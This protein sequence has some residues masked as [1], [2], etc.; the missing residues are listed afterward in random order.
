[1]IVQGLRDVLNHEVTSVHIVLTFVSRGAGGACGSEDSY[2]DLVNHCLPPTALVTR[3]SRGYDGDFS[4]AIV[5]G[6]N[7]A[8]STNIGISQPLITIFCF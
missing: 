1:M 3:M 2:V 8:P 4:L 7:R 6:A 5:G